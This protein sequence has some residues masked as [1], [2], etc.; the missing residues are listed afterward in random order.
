M[1]G[2]NISTDRGCHATEG[3]TISTDWVCDVADGESISTERGWECAADDENISMDKGC[4]VRV[5]EP[6]SVDGRRDDVDEPVRR[7]ESLDLEELTDSPVNI[8]DG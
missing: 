7:G 3:E 5:G 1:D 4:D 2:E 6:A 8:G